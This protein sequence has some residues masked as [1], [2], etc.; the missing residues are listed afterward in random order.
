M[1][2]EENEKESQE[3]ETAKKKKSKPIILLVLIVVLLGGGLMGA[4]HFYGNRILK[5]EMK[6]ESEKEKK[7]EKKSELKAGPIFTLEPFLLNLSG[8]LQRYAKI[9]V[10][11]E[12]KDPKTL[13]YAKKVVPAM[14]DK[15]IHVLGSKT[16]ETLLDVSGREAI[17]SEIMEKIKSLFEDEN[18]VKAVY[19][20]DIVIQ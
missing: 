19:I 9:S 7:A 18:S 2:G 16:A 4:Y 3:K 6:D 1:A 20:T 8:S 10:S 5:K 13:E 11:I 15:I 14:R 12:L 17:K